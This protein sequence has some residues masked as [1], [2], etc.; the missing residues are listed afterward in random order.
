MMRRRRGPKK[1]PTL[2]LTSLLDMFTIILIFL[3]VSFEAESFEFKL[4]PDL[5]LPESTARA[6]LRPAVNLA[7]TGRKVVVEEEV[8]LELQEDGAFRESQ[9]ESDSVPMLV[10][11]LEEEYQK[12]F[13]EE[14]ASELSQAVATGEATSEPI[15]VVQADRE[16]EYETLFVILRSAAEAGFF[17]YRLAV[18]RS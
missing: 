16:L 10:S 15:I 13:G 8:V 3:I 7:V 6:E 11:K 18:I 2:M 5:T 17:K 9:V 12:R 4:N 1:A 14:T